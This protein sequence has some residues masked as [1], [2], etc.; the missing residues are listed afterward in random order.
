[1][2]GRALLLAALIVSGCDGTRAAPSPTPPA[3][4]PPSA[5]PGPVGTSW[6]VDPGEAPEEFRVVF[7]FDGPRPYSLRVD[8][9]DG[10]A[11]FRVPIAG[12]GIHGADSCMARLATGAARGTTWVR[13]RGPDLR[14]FVATASSLSVQTDEPGAPEIALRDSGCRPSAS[15]PSGMDL[16]G[17]VRPALGVCVF[18]EGADAGAARAAAQTGLDDLA[19]AWAL[20]P[21]QAMPRAPVDVCPRTPHLIATNTVHPK[22]SGHGPVAPPPTVA[23]DKVSPLRLWLVVAPPARIAYAFGPAPLSTRAAEE[24]VCY[25]GSCGEVTSAIYVAQSVLGDP[26]PMRLALLTGLGLLG[27]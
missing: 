14:E 21:F 2:I 23:A 25:A 8:R 16:P 1:M 9:R 22:R 15:A 10:T 18:V 12:S 27:R 19:A 20:G 4:A 5:S 7:A 6:G 11:F 26:V 17:I 13:L 3:S 24:H